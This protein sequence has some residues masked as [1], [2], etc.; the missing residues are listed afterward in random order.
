MG[1][2]W[3]VVVFRTNG[4]IE[5]DEYTDEESARRDYDAI[6]NGGG[7]VD[8]YLATVRAEAHSEISR[9]TP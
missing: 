5:L 8:A 7:Y 6:L 9:S 4:G 1:P 2:T 3:I